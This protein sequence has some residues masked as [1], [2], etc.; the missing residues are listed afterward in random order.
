MSE[1]ALDRAILEYELSVAEHVP[2]VFNAIADALPL[3]RHPPRQPYPIAFVAHTGE[4]RRNAMIV[5]SAW[6][7]VGPGGRPTV[8][9]YSRIMLQTL[10]KVVGTIQNNHDRCALFVFVHVEHNN[11]YIIIVIG[12]YSQELVAYIDHNNVVIITT[13]YDP[14]H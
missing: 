12:I 11:E 10:S 1:L 3:W 9:S 13:I 14:H 5:S 2:G 7:R 4:P 8:R 6:V